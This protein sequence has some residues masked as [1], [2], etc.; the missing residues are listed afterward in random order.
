MKIL[1]EQALRKGTRDTALPNEND[2]QQ[3]NVSEMDQ[4]S[5][6]ADKPLGAI[7]GGVDAPVS[8]SHFSDSVMDMKSYLYSCLSGKIF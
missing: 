2:N 5:K 1:K 6:K 7:A 4:G 3:L 8:C